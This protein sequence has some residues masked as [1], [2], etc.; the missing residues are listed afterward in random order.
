MLFEGGIVPK[1]E[2]EGK[3]LLRK[4]VQL[5]NI[6]GIIELA[7]RLL[8]GNGVEE[9][10]QEAFKLLTHL[11]E[12]GEGTAGGLLGRYHYERNNMQMATFYLQRGVEL[13]SENA[14][15]NLAFMIRRGE[16]VGDSRVLP[17]NDLLLDL[18]NK[19]DLYAT[20]NYALCFAKGFQ[21]E[22][23]WQKADELF[24]S[25]SSAENSP[26]E[27]LT[28][29]HKVLIAKNNDPEGHLVIG[30]LVRH[31]FITDPDNLTILQRLTKAREGGWDVPDWMNIAVSQT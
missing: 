18:V 27:A 8:Y 23:D 2:K 30:W 31:K 13:N 1:D 21:R 25:L 26:K 4:L 20:I 3:R 22:K 17:I 16:V 29:W 5:E 14:M 7:D 9:N 19:N 12:K 6:D 24:S 11:L 28:W 15:N 10:Y